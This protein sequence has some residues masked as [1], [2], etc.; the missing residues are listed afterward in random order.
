MLLHYPLISLQ[1]SLVRAHPPP[2]L[3]LSHI[4]ISLY[5]FLIY[6]LYN[7]FHWQMNLVIMR[8]WL[9]GYSPENP[10][11]E[12]QNLNHLKLASHS[13]TFR[14]S[15]LLVEIHYLYAAPS[16]ISKAALKITLLAS[17]WQSS[18][19]WEQTEQDRHCRIGLYSRSA[20]SCFYGYF[21][22]FWKLFAAMGHPPVAFSIVY[23][24]GKAIWP[25]VEKWYKH[26]QV[27]L[28]FLE[29]NLF[30]VLPSLAQFNEEKQPTRVKANLPHGS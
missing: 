17:C 12:S 19:C 2:H 29:M 30:A 11:F 18:K 27:K 5:Y 16:H 15:T 24:T 20:L 1:C 21:E 10:S 14:F 7:I 26:F 3:L 8:H 4:Y 9:N 6:R 23:Q 13:N 25:W 28:H 22:M